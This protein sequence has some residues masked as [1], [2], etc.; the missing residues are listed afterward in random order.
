MTYLLPD[1]PEAYVFINDNTKPITKQQ[2]KNGPQIEFAP[3]ENR[4]LSNWIKS[5]NFDTVAFFWLRYDGKNGIDTEREMALTKSRYYD[6]R[7]DNQSP[8]GLK[9][10][11]TFLLLN[12]I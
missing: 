5:P 11:N 9:L 7:I 10:P 12:S 2:K 6:H 8:N 1:Q 4:D 3:G